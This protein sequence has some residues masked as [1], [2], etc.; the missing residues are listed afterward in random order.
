MAR[1]H[2]FI[3]IV[4]PDIFPFYRCFNILHICISI[5]IY[6]YCCFDLF[7]FEI[8]YRTLNFSSNTRIQ[9]IDRV[10]FVWFLSTSGQSVLIHAGASA[11]GRR[12]RE[13]SQSLKKMP[14]GD[15]YH[16]GV[17]CNVKLFI[18]LLL[19]FARIRIRPLPDP[20]NFLSKAADFYQE[21]LRAPPLPPSPPLWKIFI[22]I[23]YV[24][25]CCCLK[26]FRPLVL[27]E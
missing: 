15:R 21:W 6:M 27:V 2:Q 9:M 4:F 10:F 8:F 24:I 26:P 3:V 19:G 12:V 22:V 11:V 14:G 25:F 5:C 7:F 13:S 23:V 1:L 17:C 20:W 16:L 18:P